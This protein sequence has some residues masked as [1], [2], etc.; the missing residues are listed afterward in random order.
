MIPNVDNSSS[1]TLGSS[2][3]I[4]TVPGNYVIEW[5]TSEAELS[6][7]IPND[8]SDYSFE[9]T[10]T[11][12]SPNFVSNGLPNSGTWITFTAPLG[13]PVVTAF[14]QLYVQ[15]VIAP[16]TVYLGPL[17]ESTGAPLNQWPCFS[18]LEEGSATSGYNT[19]TRLEVF[20]SP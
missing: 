16:A 6:S 14:V 3:V 4:F 7:V 13:G 1:I 12:Q 17:S 8:H 20:S 10:I 18:A 15:V 11:N 2:S 9:Y 19:L 5:T